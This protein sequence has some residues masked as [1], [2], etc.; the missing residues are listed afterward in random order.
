MHGTSDYV[1]PVILYRVMFNAL[2]SYN[3]MFLKIQWIS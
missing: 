3:S 2:Y 1:K